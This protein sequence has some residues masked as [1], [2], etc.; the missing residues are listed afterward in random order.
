MK[1]PS[2]VV[3]VL[4]AVVVIAASWFVG[5]SI[6]SFALTSLI[7]VLMSILLIRIIFKN[8]RNLASWSESEHPDNVSGYGSI[9]KA[10]VTVEA[11][12]RGYYY[13][14]AEIAGVLR[15]ALMLR[16]GGQ[17]DGRYWRSVSTENAREDLKLLTGKNP[18][19][20]E[21][22]DPKKD[23][24][25]RRRFALR[26][27]REEEEYLSSLEEAIRIVTGRGT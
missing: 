19:V 7:L 6:L 16:F 10:A 4:L 13:S 26:S 23:G 21:I 11:A 24:G 14:R 17:S 3:P 1:A 2:F 27:S 12:A 22:F 15:T 20:L 5:L 9:T 8:S 18:R 25:Q